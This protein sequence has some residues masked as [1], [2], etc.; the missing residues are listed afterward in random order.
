MK[1]FWPEEKI[2]IELKKCQEQ[3]ICPVENPVL[4]EAMVSLVEYAYNA[5]GSMVLDAL[6]DMTQDCLVQICEAFKKYDHQRNAFYFFIG[7]VNKRL[8]RRH[9]YN[10]RLCRNRRLTVPIDND[11][12]SIPAPE[13]DEA[14]HDNYDKKRAFFLEYWEQNV[15]DHFDGEAKAVA[16]ALITAIAAQT[17]H[18]QVYQ[19]LATTTKSPLPIIRQ[20][21]QR[22]KEI[23]QRVWAQKEEKDEEFAS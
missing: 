8:L 4:Y 5:H 23:T 14:Q 13:N 9:L 19:Y 11:F 17:E 6:E 18:K 22:V 3:S 16:Q 7:V 1:P 10:T 15:H 12:D 21:V 2:R 20:T